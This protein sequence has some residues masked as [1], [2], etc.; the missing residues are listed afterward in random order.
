M[1]RKLYC[2]V[3]ESGQ[4]TQG[5]LFIVSV[6]IVGIER[7]ALREI[8]GQIEAASGKGRK[9]WTKATRKQRQAYLTQVIRKAEFRGKILY[10]RFD[11]TRDYQ[12]CVLRA[13]NQTVMVAAGGQPYRATV[14]IDGL[15][16]NERHRVTAGLRQQQLSVDKVRGLRDESDT[17]IRL[18]DAMAG[19]V[20]D[21]IE[22]ET[23]WE[24]LYQ[25]AVERGVVR[26]AKG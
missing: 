17:F 23:D 26:Q 24:R 12:G 2:Y 13:L 15:G 9:K 6:V 8:L 3:D 18:A 11:D 7:E 21:W 14:L 19:F 4:E 10:A 20:R 1:T 16:K 25:E 22:G 5:R